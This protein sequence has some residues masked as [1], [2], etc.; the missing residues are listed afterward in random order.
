M[1]MLDQWKP[2]Q[3]WTQHTRHSLVRD[4]LREAILRGYFKPGERLDQKKIARLFNVSRSPVRAA[5]VSLTVE[6]LVKNELHR[7]SIVAELTPEEVD[8]IYLIRKVLEGIAARLGAPNLTDEQIA[9]LQ[10]LMGELET[11]TDV[12]DRVRLNQ[13]FHNILYN[14]AGRPRL[15]ALI[16]TLSNTALP[17]TRQY[18]ITPEHW[19]I[20]SAGHRAIFAACLER[21][22]DQ[23]QATTEKHIAEVC[24]SMLSHWGQMPSDSTNSH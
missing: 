2:I 11:A 3:D 14:S 23:A 1:E 19:S 6:G 20:A 24:E 21:D 8:E 17:Y 13:E 18:F 5:L 9:Q 12:D 22:G 7:G 10:T 16:Q 15:Y 4:R